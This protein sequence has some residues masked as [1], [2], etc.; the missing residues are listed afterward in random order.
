MIKEGQTEEAESSLSQ[1]LAINGMREHPSAEGY[2]FNLESEG[3]IQVKELYAE[4]HT[5]AR[6]IDD[7]TRRIERDGTVRSLT[8]ILSFF[9][10]HVQLLEAKNDATSADLACRYRQ[11]VAETKAIIEA[12]RQGWFEETR[13]EAR[14]A[15]QERWV[16]MNGMTAS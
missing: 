4:V 1:W 11:D 7:G 15:H 9:A 3:S 14:A 12:L 2:A 10:I 6:L 16:T 5:Y 8:L 13:E